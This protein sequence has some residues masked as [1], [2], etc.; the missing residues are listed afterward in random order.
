MRKP[1]AGRTAAALQRRRNTLLNSAAATCHPSVTGRLSFL[2][3]FLTGWI[4][5]AMLLGVALGYFVPG[6]SRGIMRLSVGTTSLP[7][8]LGLILMM[9]PPLAKVKY[10]ELGKVFRNTR[11]LALSLVQNWVVGPLLMF[12]LAL[13]LLADKP[14]YAV[15]LIIIGLARCIAMVLVWNDLAQ[16]D[17]DYAAG[18]VAL[19]SIFQVLFFSV[20]A[21]VFLKVLPPFFGV[22]FVGVDL[23]CTHC[24]CRHGG[25]RG[26]GCLSSTPPRPAATWKRLWQ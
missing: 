9:Y 20:Y 8:A 1:D 11:I 19:N 10:E 23:A 5:L 15:G 7:I 24:C 25:S 12:G 22:H 21:Y 17:S 6:V 14:E 16:G 18:L 4:F 3:R 13:L 2:D 26:R